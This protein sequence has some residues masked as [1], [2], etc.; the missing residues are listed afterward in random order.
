MKLGI[1]QP[2]FLPYIGYFQ[3]INTVDKFVLYDNIKYTKKGW[4]NRNRILLNGRDEFI[5]LPLKKGS[6]FLNINQRY[7][8]KS[9]LL[10]K[11]KV[12]RKVEEGYRTAPHFPETYELFEDI[13][14]FDNSNLFHF[15]FNSLM[16]VCNHLKIGEEFIFS[17]TLPI[18]HTLKAEDKVLA[19]CKQMNTDHYINPIGGVKLYSKENFTKN[20][21][22]LSFLSSNPIVY[23]QPSTE[24]IPNLSI[25]DVMMFN[26]KEKILRFVNTEYTLI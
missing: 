9:F 2:Y 6:D 3:L 22:A 13:L 5:T 20:N 10:E 16:V 4:I 14:D 11:K 1:M 23:P 15:V 19:I 12:L 26:D 24:F 18:D 8:A 25:L 17:S 7:L 21:I